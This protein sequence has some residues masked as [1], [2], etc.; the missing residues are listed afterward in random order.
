MGM[1]LSP[2][3][4]A[5]AP[6]AA[7]PLP[8][9]RPPPRAQLPQASPGA[10]PGPWLGRGCLS[11]AVWAAPPSCLCVSSLEPV[12]FGL[13]MTHHPQAAGYDGAC[14][15]RQIDRWLQESKRSDPAGRPGAGV[16]EGSTG[17]AREGSVGGRLPGAIGRLADVAA[18]DPLEGAGPCVPAWSPRLQPGAQQPAPLSPSNLSVRRSRRLKSR[19]WGSLDVGEGASR[20][21]RCPWSQMHSDPTGITSHFSGILWQDSIFF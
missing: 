19:V 7:L 2:Q 4:R 21:K 13:A 15:A 17:T 6:K 1:P 8:G 16:G 14:P 20:R 11:S 3:H 18:G 10:S 12:E 5:L 9:H